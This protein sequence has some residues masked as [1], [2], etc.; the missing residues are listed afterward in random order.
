MK[1]IIK[2]MTFTALFVSTLSLSSCEK[3]EIENSTSD[4]YSYQKKLVLNSNND[5][6]AVELLIQS[7][8]DGL[9]TEYLEFYDL[10]LE[11][12]SDFIL[13]TS[14]LATNPSIENSLNEKAGINI[15][16]VSTNLGV[17]EVFTIYFDANTDNIASELKMNFTAKATKAMIQLTNNKAC[18]NFNYEVSS[19]KAKNSFSKESCNEFATTG[20]VLQDAAIVAATIENTNVSQSYAVSFEI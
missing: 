4:T 10:K 12:L 7:D 16:V 1:T 14:L 8:Q 19:N 13:P 20:V 9:I 2:I 15:E 18:A 17:N 11:V 6:Y 5:S 3:T